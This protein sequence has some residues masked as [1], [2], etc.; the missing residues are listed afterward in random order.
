MEESLTWVFCMGRLCTG[1]AHLVPGFV[2]LPLHDCDGACALCFPGRTQ[3]CSCSYNRDHLTTTAR[4]LPWHP[5][6]LWLCSSLHHPLG[7]P[8][9]STSNLW[10]PAR[11][12]L[13]F[14]HGPS[15][16]SCPTQS[17]REICTDYASPSWARSSSKA[18]PTPWCPGPS[19]S[20]PPTSRCK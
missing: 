19:R 8:L 18:T 9:L 7:C 6:D 11:Q 10:L 4:L 13:A 17:I 1:A 15:S 12:I 14:C 5:W 3:M 16:L 20:L 2:H